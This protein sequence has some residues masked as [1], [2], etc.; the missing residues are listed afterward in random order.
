[1]RRPLALLVD[2][3]NLLRRGLIGL[4]RR[5]GYEVME[6]QNGVEALAQVKARTPDLVVTD[7]HMPHMDGVELIRRLREL[8]EMEEKP[9]MVVTADETRA[10][11]INLLQSGAD[12]FI[13][14]PI[15]PGE[16]QARLRALGRRSD[17]VVALESTRVE[18]DSAL[19]AVEQ[20]NRELE[21]LTMGLVVALERANTLN[22]SDT[23]N[24]IR[25]V[26]HFAAML[27]HAH[28]CEAEFV[29]QV[30]R[31]AGLHDVGKVGLRD[32][33]LKKPGKLTAEE[34][35]EMTTHT[36]IGGELLRSAGL[37][38]VACNIALCHHERWDGTGYPRG[39]SGESI[40]LEARV[41]AVADVYDA[42]R[43]KRC[44]KP[45]FSWEKTLE[46]MNEMAGSHLQ[47]NLVTLFFEHKDEIMAISERFSDE[48]DE[49]AEAT[50]IWG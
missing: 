49:P 29:E 11:K 33:I 35:N 44:Y 31:Y 10:T 28:S 43:S 24:H 38:E 37:H 23:G 26:S 25:R 9:I 39:L 4:A 19:E 7:L 12:D 41:V 17:L 47:E 13:C 22:D 34:F 6:A 20:R 48:E 15:D 2:D 16:F 8:P 3:D 32:T 14:K 36:L 18:R 46:I 40:P 30:R 5:C 21:Q 42:L 1:M 50:E 45:T 27:A